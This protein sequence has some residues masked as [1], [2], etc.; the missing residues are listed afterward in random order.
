MLLPKNAANECVVVFFSSLEARPNNPLPNPRPQLLQMCY[1]R[2]SCNV[3][4]PAGNP[5]TQ[6]TGSIYPIPAPAP[7]PHPSP[8]P[9]PS[10]PT[11]TEL[12][13]STACIGVLAADG[14]LT[15]FCA[16]DGEATTTYTAITP[17]A[18]N[19]TT[20]LRKGMVEVFLSGSISVSSDPVLG[21]HAD[22][23]EWTLESAASTTRNTG[24]SSSSGGGGGGESGVAAAVVVRA[25]DLGFGFVGLSSPS[26]QHYTT[27]QEKTWCPP[28][29]GCQSWHGSSATCTIGGTPAR[30]NTSH[31]TALGRHRA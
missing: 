27:H 25:I 12:P 30:Q 5:H 23:L 9:G 22:T 15:Q 2:L 7:R 31:R 28:R 1:P 29:T 21:R 3:T 14:N 18:A 10:P 13:A 16:A 24:T 8:S 26:D 20:V 17:T 4:Q 11:P 19:W 6:I